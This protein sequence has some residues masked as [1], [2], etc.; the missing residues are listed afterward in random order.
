[1]KVMVDTAESTRWENAAWMY[2]ARLYGPE[3]VRGG[4]VTILGKITP[5]LLPKEFGGERN[6]DWGDDVPEL[7]RMLNRG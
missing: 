2:F 4:D 5:R 6:V 1:M 3:N 7:I